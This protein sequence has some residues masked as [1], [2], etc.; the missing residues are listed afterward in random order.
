MACVTSLAYHLIAALPG[1]R[2]SEKVV[3]F[4]DFTPTSA[5]KQEAPAPAPPPVVTSSAF[6][7]IFL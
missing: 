1:I 2:R 7:M 5:C 3:S 6:S 4:Y